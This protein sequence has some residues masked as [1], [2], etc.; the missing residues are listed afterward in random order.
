MKKKILHVSYSKEFAGYGHAARTDLRALYNSDLDI[1]ARA[2]ELK[3]TVEDPIV[4]ELEKRSLD[5]ITHVIQYLVPEHW[6]RFPGVKNIGYFEVESD[7]LSYSIWPE[8]MNHVDEIWVPNHEARKAV[9]KVTALPVYVVPHAVD[10]TVYTKQYP[11]VK[12]R[13]AS[14]D[15]FFYTIAENIPR[16]N[17]VNLI[18][19][20]FIEFDPTEPVSLIIKTTSNL[21]NMITS[22]QKRIKLYPNQTDYQQIAVIDRPISEDQLYGLHQCSNC[23]VNSSMGES[24]CLPLVDA[25]G[26]N[27]TIIT[28]NVGGPH[29]I[30]QNI[31]QF[32]NKVYPVNSI[33][34]WCEGHTN[35]PGLQ[36]GRDTWNQFDTTEMRQSMRAAYNNKNCK[37]DIS[38]NINRYSF[39]N[40]VARINELCN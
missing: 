23:Y 25:I 24:W 11:P 37:D 10:S 22:I 17:L 29:D 31:K 19:C 13:Q 30:I 34:T 12:I 7:D 2:Y 5:N 18:A 40:Y 39:E 20:Y 21:D 4:Q 6:E 26:F 1:T 28:I 16:K 9:S 32:E 33:K 36:N 14:C 3:P 8:C 35:F 27:K 38:H 15:Y